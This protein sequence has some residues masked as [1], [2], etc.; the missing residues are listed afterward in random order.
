[1]LFQAS[2]TPPEQN[3]C[4]TGFNSEHLKFCTFGGTGRRTLVLFGDSHAAQW[5][6]ALRDISPDNWHIVTL[7]K[8][9]C[10]SASV[11][12]YNPHME[13]L[14]TNCAKW[15]QAALGFIRRTKPAIVV[16]VNSSGY[17][18]RPFFED[19]YAYVTAQEWERGMRMTLELLN[20][21]VTSVLLVRDTPRAPFDIPVCLSRAE[22]HP[23]L[24]AA[25][26]CTLPE[27][28]SLA[29][30]VWNAELHAV[31][32]LP[33]VTTLDL[34]SRFC[35]DGHCSPRVDNIIVYRD[36]NHITGAFA[37]TFAPVFEHQLQSLGNTTRFDGR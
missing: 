23:Y 11:P 5:I 26:S 12:I 21:G 9:S 10:P 6:P 30:P 36:S 28:T 32:G 33:F 37:S 15:R 2:A 18:K 27:E 8:A 22:H 16:L 17:V 25:V 4:M 1:M 7:L 29:G 3:T 13:R 34:T 31:K 19:P 24:F 20:N 14:D 35:H